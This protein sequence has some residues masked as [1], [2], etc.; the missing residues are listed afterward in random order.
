[1]TF[2]QYIILSEIDWAGGVNQPEAGKPA[3]LKA[4]KPARQ[5]AGKLKLL[6]KNLKRGHAG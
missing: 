4:G 1:M 3:R 2:C 5:T 6:T